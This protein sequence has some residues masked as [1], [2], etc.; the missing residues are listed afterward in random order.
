MQTKYRPS[1]AEILRFGFFGL[2]HLHLTSLMFRI[3]RQR[4]TYLGYRA[5]MDL[6]QAV[7]QVESSH[8][9]GIMLEAGCALGG[10]AI[11]IAASK[12]AQRPLNVYDTFNVIPPP[13]TADGN[14]AD[15]HYKNIKAGQAQGIN[16][17]LYYGYKHNLLQ[18]VYDSF[19]E[20]HLPIEENHVTLVPGLF[21]DTLLLSSPVALA[22]LDC[23]W[24]ES[25][26]TCLNRIVPNL[27][28]GGILV[29][30]DYNDWAGCRQAVDEYFADKRSS[31]RFFHKSRLHIQ[32]IQ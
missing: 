10:S 24:Y 3:R 11:M 7:Q 27:S 14:Q 25:V 21:N 29:I 28:Q 18:K 1:T 20:H 22:H 5:L 23:D 17:D 4:L 2:T 16:G 6:A 9:P 26:Q 31:Y 15:L 19:E 13:T 12:S 30:D 32:R 8:A